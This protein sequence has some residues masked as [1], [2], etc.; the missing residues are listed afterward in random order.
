MVFMM[1]RLKMVRPMGMELEYGQ[2]EINMKDIG[3]MEKWMEKES[4]FGQVE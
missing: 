1:G 4:M 3:K 2:M